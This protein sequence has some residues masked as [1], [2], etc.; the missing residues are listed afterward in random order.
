M[1]KWIALLIAVLTLCSSALAENTLPVYRA[2]PRSESAASFFDK[3]DPDWFNQSGIAMQE[4]GSKRA[5]YDVFT[6][7]DQA[8][9]NIDIGYIS[10]EEYDGEHYMIYG[11]D[12]KN[13]GGPFPRPSFA[14]AVG[15]TAGTMLFRFEEQSAGSKPGLIKKEM[16]GITLAQA[17]LQVQTLLG[18]LGLT[19]YELTTAVDMNVD[20]IREWGVWAVA[21]E[22]FSYNRY[23]RH[24]DFTSAAEADEGYYLIYTPRLNGLT[25]GHPDGWQ[26]VRAFVNAGGIVSFQLRSAYAAGEVY[27]M[28][29]KL[30]TAKEIH[31]V[32]EADNER[33]IKDGFLDPVVK[34]MELMYCPM[35][36]PEKQEGMV[37]T[38]AWYLEYSVTDGAPNDGWVWYS[39]VDGKLISDCY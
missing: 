28:P 26:D 23:D 34:S 17:D 38:P 35:R 27:S 12:P 18:K 9:L 39:A 4:N 2:V 13:P 10:Y 33:R 25:V 24:Y 8:Q 6:F 7:N 20:R 15:Q 5:R 31:E 32:F 11:E 1:K 21:E 36:A 30:L 16:S 3:A 37:L 29:E 22:L 19:G 14:N